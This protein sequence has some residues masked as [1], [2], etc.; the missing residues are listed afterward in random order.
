MLLPL[1]EFLRLVFEAVLENIFLDFLKFI[2]LGFLI[3]VPYFVILVFFN[4]F[5][6]QSLQLYQV[7]NC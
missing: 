7:D 2:F 3:L 1:S 6:C 5:R 4:D